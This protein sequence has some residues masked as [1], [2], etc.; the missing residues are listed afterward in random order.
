MNQEDN[1]N[2]EMARQFEFIKDN[3]ENLNE[4]QDSLCKYIQENFHLGLRQNK[5]KIKFAEDDD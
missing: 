2:E 4:N 1:I 3:I 5:E